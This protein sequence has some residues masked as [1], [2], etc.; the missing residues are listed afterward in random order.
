MTVAEATTAEVTMVVEAISCDFR[1]CGKDVI[2]M[3]ARIRA[4][5]SCVRK[6]E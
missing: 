5:R 6:L 4:V 2:P 1:V 3:E